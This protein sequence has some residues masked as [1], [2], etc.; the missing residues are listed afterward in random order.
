MKITIKK[1]IE[2]TENTIMCL[3]DT[4]FYAIDYWAEGMYVEAYGDVKKEDVKEL[5]SSEAYA[6]ILC[7]GGSLKVVDRGY[8][9]EDKV[10]DLKDF[11]KGLR[12]S[13]EKYGHSFDTDDIASTDTTG[14]DI[15]MQMVLFDEIVFG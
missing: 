10:F 12:K 9:F 6:K 8:D 7:S 4:S 11:L 5:S 14:C 15:I 2:L 1:T 13:I 3:L